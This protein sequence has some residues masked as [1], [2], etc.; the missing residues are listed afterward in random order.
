[1]RFTCAPILAPKIL[2]LKPGEKMDLSYRIMV[3]CQLWTPE[4][5]QGEL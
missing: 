1:M 4:A 5:L 3:R 2:T